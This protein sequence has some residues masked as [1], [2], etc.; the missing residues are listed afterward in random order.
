MRLESEHTHYRTRFEM[1]AKESSDDVLPHVLRVMYDWLS[2]KERKLHP[3]DESSELLRRLEGTAFDYHVEYPSR[4]SC[5][6]HVSRALLEGMSCPNAY[7]GGIGTGEDAKLRSSSMTGDGIEGFPQYWAMDYDEPDTSIPERRW[8]TSVGVVSRG[9]SCVV[10][11]RI[12]NYLLPSYV[13]PK[14]STPTSTTPNFVRELI[15]LHGFRAR[16][17]STVLSRRFTWVGNLQRYK[18][19]FIKPLMDPA[20]ELP[21]IVVA[22]DY[23]GKAPTDARDLAYKSLGMA[24]VLLLDLKEYRVRDYVRQTFVEGAPAFEHRVNANSVRVYNP[25]LNP[26]S[27]VDA[28][29]HRLFSREDIERLGDNGF[30][31]MLVRS[32]TRGWVQDDEDVVDILDVAARARRERNAD[33]RRRLDELS[34]ASEERARERRRRRSGS[35]A[36]ATVAE[37]RQLLE[38]RDREIARLED[39]NAVWHGM[40]EE[41]A[42]DLEEVSVDAERREEKARAELAG[43]IAEAAQKDEEIALLGDEVK[44]LGYDLKSAW[45]QVAQITSDLSGARHALSVYEGISHIPGKLSEL[46]EVLVALYPDRVLVLDEAR[47]SAQAFDGRY[48]LDDEWAILRSVPTTLW[49]LY[50]GKA[51]SANVQKDYQAATSFELALTEGSMT[52]KG[53]KYMKQRERTYR[54]QTVSIAPHIKGR[55]GNSNDYFRLHYHADNERKVIVIGHCGAHLDTAGTNKVKH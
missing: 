26:K 40:A 49:D 46:L 27:A 30:N 17:G 37:L 1:Y 20:R 14:P 45:G 52:N 19:A 31:D 54:G 15:M 28:R 25:G 50:F 10:N 11:I 5:D 21:L 22:T 35:E 23:E 29:R 55:S 16:I 24:K 51:P 32:L 13:G 43:Y 47:K 12:T 41:Y 8:H 53:A 3:G 2:A 18:D 39:D 42:G 6:C 38:E 36:D 7:D 9:K 44:K 33:L 48:D 4:V 34:R